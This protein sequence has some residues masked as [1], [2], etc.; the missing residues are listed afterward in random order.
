[1]SKKLQDPGKNSRHLWPKSF[2]CLLRK[3]T[4]LMPCLQWCVH[5]GFVS[6]YII[7]IVEHYLFAE[8]L[9][10]DTNHVVSLYWGSNMYTH[11]MRQINPINV[12]SFHG[13]IHRNGDMS[14]KRTKTTIKCTR[15]KRD[16]PSPRLSCKLCVS[17]ANHK[18]HVYRRTGTSNRWK[19]QK[20]TNTVRR[21]LI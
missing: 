13:S 9:L 10:F 1:M 16:P 15:N 4:D 6:N 3:N 12:V 21:R 7:I 2:M 20:D 5:K 19:V 11:T 8:D 18:E 17:S 14:T